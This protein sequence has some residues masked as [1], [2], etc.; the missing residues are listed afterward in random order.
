MKKMK[1]G[2]GRRRK[3]MTMDEEDEGMRSKKEMMM[4][5]GGL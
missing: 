3:K 1:V 2:E 4:K 5:V